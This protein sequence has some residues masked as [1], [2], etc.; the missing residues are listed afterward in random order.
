MPHHFIEPDRLFTVVCIAKLF[1]RHAALPLAKMLGANFIGP[2]GVQDGK[3][4]AIQV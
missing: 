2:D 1:R 4:P 3:Q